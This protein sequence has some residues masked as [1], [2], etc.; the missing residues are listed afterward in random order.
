M[1]V[2]CMYRYIIAWLPSHF[3]LSLI[4]NFATINLYPK[5]SFMTDVKI[6]ELSK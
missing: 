2:S 1:N 4:D 5:P 3:N 6:A